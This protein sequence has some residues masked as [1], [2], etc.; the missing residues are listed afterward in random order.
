MADARTHLEE[1]LK[2]ASAQAEPDEAHHQLLQ[3]LRDENTKLRQRI[4]DST[5]ARVQLEEKLRDLEHR[6]TPEATAATIDA[7]LREERIRMA[8]ERAELARQRTKLLELQSELEKRTTRDD[9]SLTESDTRLRAFRDHLRE[10]HEDEQRERKENTL[11]NRLS[12][13]WKRLDG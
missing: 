7:A 12:R 11:A 1:Q 9:K 6:G 2:T 8:Q 4:E 13:L 3:T 10:I 5:A